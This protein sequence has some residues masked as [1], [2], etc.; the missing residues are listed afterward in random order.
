METER[1]E[2]TTSTKNTTSAGKAVARL[3]TP[4]YPRLTAIGKAYAFMF[5]MNDTIGREKMGQMTPKQ[6]G[7]VR[8]IVDRLYTLI[9]TGELPAGSG[10]IEQGAYESSAEIQALADPVWF[11]DFMAMVEQHLQPSFYDQNSRAQG[12]VLTVQEFIDRRLHVSGMYATIALTEFG[13]DQYLP[14]E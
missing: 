5:F 11:R 13:D 7:E 10:P 6:I 12:Q 9:H 2:N 3:A 4:N 14:W 8:R 1:E